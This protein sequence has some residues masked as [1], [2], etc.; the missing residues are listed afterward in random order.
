MTVHLQVELDKLKKRILALGAMVEEQLYNA[1]KALKDRD[2]GLARA[3]VESDREIDAWEVEVEE[4]CLKILALHQPVAADLRFIIAVIKINNDLERI[5][6]EA[7]NIAEA[8]TY[9]AGRPAV[10]HPFDFERMARETQGMLKKSLDALVNLDLDLA[11]QVGILDDEVDHLYK[12]IHDGVKRLIP[13][14]PQRVGSLIKL[15]L[16]SRHLER[17]ADHA[18]NIAEEVIYMIEGL[19]PRHAR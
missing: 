19:I 7:V 1:V 10:S 16:I 3:V 6:D 15:L 13:D 2:G 4:E 11:Y 8:V 9:L 12:E 17:V 18:T 5:G 14:L